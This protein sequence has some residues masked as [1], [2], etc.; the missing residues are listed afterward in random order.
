MSDFKILWY[1]VNLKIK[2]FAKTNVKHLYIFQ[3]FIESENTKFYEMVIPKLKKYWVFILS[4]Q[5][6]NKL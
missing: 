5:V 3:Q 1:M 6:I 2:I 4:H